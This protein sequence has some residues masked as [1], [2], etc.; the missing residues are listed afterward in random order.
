[1]IDLDVKDKKILY[2]LEQDARQ[3]LRNLGKK[4]GL[5]KDVVSNRVKNLEEKGVIFNYY[6]V[7]NIFKLDLSILRFYIKMQFITSEIKEEIIKWF[8]ENK[9]SNV[10][11]SVEGSYDLLVIFSIKNIHK[12]YNF[13]EETLDRFG[14]Y[15]ESYNFSLYYEEHL[16]D[17][18][19]LLDS[20]DRKDDR[21]KFVLSSSIEQIEIDKLDIDILKII[22]PN[23][24]IPTIEI[25]N[26]LNT[27]ASIIHYR[28]KKL[29]DL[30]L[31]MGYRATL[32]FSKLGLKTFKCDLFLKDHKLTNKIMKYVVNNPY[33]RGR[34]I[35]I[36]NADIEL[37]YYLKDVSSLNQIIRDISNKFP[38]AI[39]NYKYFS[40]IR[41]HKYRY[42]PEE[43]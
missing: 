5:S 39:R 12:I 36:G 1:M 20:K 35:A 13:W 14:D 15:F 16:Y 33:L 26:K 42:I 32:D 6:T 29:I 40:D 21:K 34:D 30:G 7:I 22:A 19:F 2:Y 3:S 9:Y 18:I 27:T 38:G 37:T 23:A 8:L 17:H 28:I 41:L 43:F 25:A 10:V 11:A 24:R 31:I 4:V